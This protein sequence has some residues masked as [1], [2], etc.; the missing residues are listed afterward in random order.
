MQALT[1]FDTEQV[2]FFSLASFVNVESGTTTTIM[3]TATLTVAA[4]VV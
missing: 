4:I 3:P 2:M 1:R